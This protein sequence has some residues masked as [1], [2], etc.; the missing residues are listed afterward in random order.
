MCTSYPQ[1]IHAL[2]PDS[3]PARSTDAS[4]ARAS[5]S[6]SPSS[7]NSRATGQTGQL[8]R[9]TSRQQYRDCVG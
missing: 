8:A 4:N 3:G 9:L 7:H 6:A 2:A 1:L 5:A